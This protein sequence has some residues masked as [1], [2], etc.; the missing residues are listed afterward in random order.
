MDSRLDITGNA[1]KIQPGITGKYRNTKSMIICQRLLSGIFQRRPA[2]L[3]HIRNLT[4][5]I[6]LSDQ[7]YL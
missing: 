6:P 2:C 4:V 5:Q 7:F 1:I 3:W